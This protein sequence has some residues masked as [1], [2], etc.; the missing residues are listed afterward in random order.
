MN[1]KS[2]LKTILLIWGIISLCA[3]II[4][5]AYIAKM[6]LEQKK[7]SSTYKPEYTE[8]TFCEY[9]LK[10]TIN[11]T[12]NPDII[13]ISL[14]QQGNAL[15]TNY[16]LPIEKYGLAY[17]VRIDSAVAVDAGKGVKGI[18]LISNYSECACEN[19]D[20]Y[21]WFL[22]R[23]DTAVSI[24]GVISISDLRTAKQENTFWGNRHLY[25]DE[26]PNTHF[27]VPTEVSVGNNIK[28]RPLLDKKGIEYL[29]T[30]YEAE[31]KRM[32]EMLAK[33]GDT[34][35]SKKYNDK[36]ELFNDMIK[37]KTIRF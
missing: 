36:N 20:Q 4:I 26:A 2:V 29:S 34:T 5:G 12:A 22:T 14:L 37:G 33:S 8:K 3:V 15:L 6:L 35:A 13:H 9:I 30:A 25:L 7:S 31:S 10:T 28:I 19:N 21:L 24:T 17:G 32:F 23:T 18:V 16:C 1:T 27:S 11:D